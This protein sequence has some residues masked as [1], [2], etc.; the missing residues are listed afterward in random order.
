MVNL[1][2]VLALLSFAIS[3]YFACL[4]GRIGVYVGIGFLFVSVMFYARTR[5]PDNSL[6][7]RWL[8]R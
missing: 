4:F 3:L 5:T 8:N 1:N 7:L 2:Y 6:I